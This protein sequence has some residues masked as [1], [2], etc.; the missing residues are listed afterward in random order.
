MFVKPFNNVI[1]SSV[2]KSLNYLS[3]KERE[4]EF[5]IIANNYLEQ[6]IE[7]IHY[8]LYSYNSTIVNLTIA[9]GQPV[10]Y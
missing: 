10:L 4:L 1:S 8:G 2:D 9:G 3:L 7:F 6:Q 5:G